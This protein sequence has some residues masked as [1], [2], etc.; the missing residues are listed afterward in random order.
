LIAGQS[1]SGEE[2]EA[3]HEHSDKDSYFSS[4]DGHCS[5]DQTSTCRLSQLL[6]LPK[7]FL[8]QHPVDFTAF[9][10][11][12]VHLAPFLSKFCKNCVS[13]GLIA[14]YDEDVDQR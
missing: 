13:M 2:I 3:D 5:H 8:Q 6:Y 12:P 7:L 1:K 9:H 10:H 11:H 4:A 14:V